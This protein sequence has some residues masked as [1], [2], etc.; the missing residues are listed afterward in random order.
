[1]SNTNNFPYSALDIANYIVWYVNKSSHLSSVTPLKLQKILYYVSAKYLRDTDNLLFEEQIQK[2]QYGPVVK[3][4]YHEF[5]NIGI[6]NISS[7]RDIL[8]LSKSKES[9]F[10]FEEKKFNVET[11]LE[12]NSFI[13]I[14]NSV[15]DELGDKNAFDLVERTHSEHAWKRLETRIL[16]GEKDLCY[17]DNELKEAKI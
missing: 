4:V 1:M 14:A 9:I 3:S 12:D 10:G 8:V 2:W 11:F 5:K 6:R 16:Q 13:K 7:P 17:T 15:I